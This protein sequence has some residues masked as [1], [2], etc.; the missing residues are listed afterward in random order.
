MSRQYAEL[1]KRV[2]NR[3]TVAVK[4]HRNRVNRIKKALQKEKYIHKKARDMT[5]LPGFGKLNSVVHAIPGE[6]EFVRL[7][8]TLTYSGDLL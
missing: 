2:A 6:E 7:E 4:C 8:F 3:E 1:W 5:G